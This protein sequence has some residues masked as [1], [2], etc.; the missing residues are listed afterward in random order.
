MAQE[1]VLDR[2][3][4]RS[5]VSWACCPSQASHVHREGAGAPPARSTSTAR[6]TGYLGERGSHLPSR[7]W[8]ALFASHSRG[9]LHPLDMVIIREGKSR[10]HFLLGLFPKS[11][12]HFII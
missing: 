5:W 7:S 6:G 1:G 12:I 2:V 3:S 4:G 10:I 11:K 9:V 8:F